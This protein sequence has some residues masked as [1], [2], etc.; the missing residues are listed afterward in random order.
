MSVNPN[1]IMRCEKCYV[2]SYDLI[3]LQC[4]NCGHMT[5]KHKELV[6]ENRENLDNYL[7]E[8]RVARKKYEDR[9]WRNEE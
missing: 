2:Q 1:Y 6:G 7:K 5:D 9:V 4:E 3:F 8:R